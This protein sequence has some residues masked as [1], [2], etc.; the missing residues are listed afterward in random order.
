MWPGPDSRR[1][2]RRSRSPCR[3]AG[4]LSRY[5]VRGTPS[6]GPSYPPARASRCSVMP[7]AG[8]IAALEAAAFRWSWCPP[9]S[10]LRSGT[11]SGRD[12]MVA[13]EEVRRDMVTTGSPETQQHRGCPVAD[14][15]RGIRL[16]AGS[17]AA[18]RSK[19]EPAG[20]GGCTRK[21]SRM[22]RPT[23]GIQP[24]NHHPPDRFVSCRR[25]REREPRDERRETPKVVGDQ[26]VKA[27][28]GTPFSLTIMG[29]PM[30]VGQSVEHAVDDPNGQEP[31]QNSLRLARPWKTRIS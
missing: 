14:G 24:M 9:S 18:S 26:D 22:I 16:T 27:G 2:V 29:L 23:M 28:V 1:G 7:S 4:G 19:R 11:G 25:R 30:G 5:S 3:S 8:V 13:D 15:P 31:H 10:V 20:L 21:T 12:R 17:A 6:F